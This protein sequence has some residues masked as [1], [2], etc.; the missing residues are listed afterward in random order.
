MGQD[1]LKVFLQVFFFF[2]APDYIP[3]AFTLS[4]QRVGFFKHGCQITTPAHTVAVGCA[5]DVLRSTMRFPGDGTPVLE[6][7]LTS[8]KSRDW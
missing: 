7:E 5:E 6:L 1:A 8:V 2:V 4:L 3:S